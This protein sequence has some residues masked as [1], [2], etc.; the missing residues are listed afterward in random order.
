MRK[1]HLFLALL[2]T[3]S[4]SF[5]A[6]PVADDSKIVLDIETT[7]SHQLSGFDADGD[8]IT[9]SLH[10]SGPANG[11]INI[12][13]D[14]SYTYAP[15]V[16]FSGVDSFQYQISDGTDSS[17]VT[18]DIEV[19]DGTTLL[20]YDGTNSNDVLFGSNELSSNGGEFQINSY[21]NDQQAAP[22]IAA[23]EDGS[24]VVTWLSRGQDGDADGIFGQLFDASGY[25]KGAEFPVNSTTI[26]RQ[27]NPSIATFSDG[28]FVVSW[29]SGITAGTWDIFAQRFDNNAQPIGSE[30]IVN[31]LTTGSQLNTT[32]V[33]LSND[34]FVIV[35][36]SR[37]STSYSIR[38]QRYDSS[39]NALGGEFQINSFSPDNVNT[40]TYD[41]A[42]F[43]PSATALSDGGFVVSWYSRD[44][45]TYNINGQ[46]FDSLGNMVG[47][48]FTINS[49]QNS[50]GVAYPNIAALNDGGFIA[51]WSS[52][53]VV[54]YD[55]YGQRFDSSGNAI[56]N[57]FLVNT[58]TADTQD[59]P[60]ITALNNG[61][62]VINWYSRGQ[63]GFGLGTYAQ[64]YNA[65]A[66]PVGPEFRVN[67]TIT[68]SEYYA[69]G[70]SLSNDDFVIVWMGTGALAPN[71]EL[72]VYGQRYNLD[73]TAINKAVISG[74]SG[75]DL[76]SGN[77]GNDVFVGG[78]G[79]DT[80]V[81]DGIRAD[82]AIVNNADG[83]I[84][85]SDLN[86]ADGDEGIDSLKTVEILQF[87]DT[88]I[89][90]TMVPPVALD[91]SASLIQGGTLNIA[92][93]ANDRSDNGSLNLNSLV[94]TTNASHGTIT[95][96]TD[97]SVNYVHDGSTS[98]SDSFS[99]TVTD[100]TGVTSN[101]ANVSLDITL[102]NTPPIAVNDNVST[103]EDTGLTIDVLANDSDAEQDPLTI[104]AVTN[105]TL[106]GG[107]TLNNNGNDITYTPNAN[108][109]GIDSFD[110]F[111]DDGNGE[112]ASASVTITVNP[113]ND[114]PSAVDDIATAV[115][116]T[117]AVIDVL[118]NDSDVDGNLLTISNISQASNGTV[119]NNGSNVTYIADALF[120]GSDSFSYTIDDGN[121][122]LAIG[123]VNITVIGST[124]YDYYILNPKMKDGSA[125]VVSLVNNN[126]ITAGST[127]LLLQK[128]ELGTIPASDL[129]QGAKISGSGAFSFGSA[130]NATD[131]PAH[132]SLAGKS[133]VIPHLRNTHL[134]FILSPYGNAN[135]VINSG[136]G[137]STITA[138]QNQVLTFNAGNTNAIASTLTADLP[139][140][141]VHAGGS[142]T[143]AN[144]DVYAVPPASNSLWGMRKG[145]RVGATEDN[146]TITVYES[147]GASNSFT[148]NSGEL[149]AISIGDNANQSAGSALHIVADKPIAA[150]EYADSDGS[151]STAFY[152][153]SYLSTHYGIPVDTQYIAIAC[154]NVSTTVTLYDGANT[155]QVQACNGDG[156]TP[157]KAYF[158]SVSNGLNINAGAYLESNLP[159]YV[160]YETSLRND[161]HNLLGVLG[162]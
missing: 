160:I 34:D 35:W 120:T 38:G 18:V 137:P 44:G 90:P 81:F 25:P 93:V 86:T 121:G 17:I 157:G 136:S 13:T 140:L 85:V 131:M 70:T 141:V 153:E 132:A 20:T 68:G 101:I 97:G 24:Y 31:T 161:E 66:S 145:A 162:P 115:G 130:E 23:F 129:T 83:S 128:N 116:T 60:K 99:Y 33:A 95:V 64:R 142:S 158:G 30:F 19:G 119:I 77:A 74:G 28:T 89:D 96:N 8:L 57:L 1:L 22:A 55:I 94:I 108:F 138:T 102:I 26:N 56:G 39:G 47:S 127:T 62:F 78:D 88:D 113:I 156:T 49:G 150:I 143:N 114:L 147:N 76:L 98:I 42:N 10:G 69:V 144:K 87:S 36:S 124:S 58:H 15:S 139:I 104:F 21:T 43:I 40:Y 4:S 67:T 75:N 125:N 111:I 65:S 50:L 27:I 5:A 151:E 63:D 53:D 59:I 152:N 61:G 52:T 6:A 148:L 118:S 37:P 133:F 72:N 48:E 112:T 84:T 105:P 103:N 146:T 100:S 91:D 80:A 71:E 32:V 109:N 110:Y 159:I 154:P 134:Y 107:I 41:S 92:L 149:Q 7:I 29:A 9:Y 122:G 3:C 2:T 51:T 106:Y 123:N 12:N 45:S 11:T 82:Y 126:T 79:Q 117:P 46:R 14:G 135:V 155:P 54:S 73:G 16:G